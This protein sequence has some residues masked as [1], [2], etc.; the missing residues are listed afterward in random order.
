[1]THKP[2][3]YWFRGCRHI[4]VS[5]QFHKDR[6]HKMSPREA[7]CVHVL[8]WAQVLSHVWLFVTPRTGARQTPL[9]RPNILQ[10]KYWSGLPFLSPGDLPDPG[11]EPGSPE[12]QA[13]SLPSEEYRIPQKSVQIKMATRSSILTWRIPW[14]EG[15]GGY[16]P[17]GHKESDTSERLTLSSLL[18]YIYIY[19]HVHVHIHSQNTKTVIINPGGLTVLTHGYTVNNNKCCV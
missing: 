13:D 9:S 2:P 7:V 15:P 12:L 8:R 11:I 16:S 18:I 1:M 19:T 4:L 5:K 14:T 17:W 6:K 10:Q 3:K